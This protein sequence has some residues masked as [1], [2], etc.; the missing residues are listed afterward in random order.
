[1]TTDSLTPLPAGLHEAVWEHCD[2][3]G[4][5]PDRIVARAVREWLIRRYGDDYGPGVLDA[6][7]GNYAGWD[8]AR[9]ATH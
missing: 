9:R 2:L 7:Y 5:T 3:R 4:G 1:M 6:L 8:E